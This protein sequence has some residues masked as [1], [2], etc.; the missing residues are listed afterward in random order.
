MSTIFKDKNK[1]NEIKLPYNLYLSHCLCFQLLHMMKNERGV[2]IPF[3]IYHY[4]SHDVNGANP[5]AVSISSRSVSG[6]VPYAKELDSNPFLGWR[7]PQKFKRQ[8]SPAHTHTLALSFR[9]L[10]ERQEN[11]TPANDFK[12]PT[13][14]VTVATPKSSFASQY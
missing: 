14:I 13:Q 11:K 12:N 2:Q 1:I 10:K 6:E 3:I 9:I 4:G 8:C 5:I 7:P